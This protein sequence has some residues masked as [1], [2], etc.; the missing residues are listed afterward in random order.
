[1]SERRSQ[2]HPLV[3]YLE[4]RAASD[5]RAMLAALRA[6]LR[7]SL[8]EGHELEALRIVLPVLPRNASRREEDDATLLAGLFALHPE[9]GSLSLAGAMRMI[10]QP[11]GDTSTFENVEKRFQ[12][13]LAATR[14]DLPN[15]LRHAISLVAAHELGLDWNDLFRAIKYWDHE[16]DFVRRRWARSFW[17]G[18]VH[19]ATTPE[20]EFATTPTGVGS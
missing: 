5:D 7:A 11:V 18:A 13:L 20:S 1:M 9:S 12:A 3:A 8:R 14:A 2:S 16:D 17:G 15:H 10:W 19:D 6:S 4:E